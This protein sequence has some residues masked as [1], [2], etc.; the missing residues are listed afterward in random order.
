MPC[1]VSQ[2]RDGRWKVVDDAPV[3]TGGEPKVVGIWNK[4]PA[5][6]KDMHQRNGTQPAMLGNLAEGEE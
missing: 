3:A 5:A 2:G 4:H 6:V 1:T